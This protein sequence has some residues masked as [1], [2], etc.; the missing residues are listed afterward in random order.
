MTHEVL[1]LV[2]FL[3]S[4]SNEIAGNEQLN[5]ELFGEV[6]IVSFVT[7]PTLSL[8]KFRL[9]NYSSS[10]LMASVESV[11]LELGEEHK[12]LTDITLF[13]LE[14]DEE[15]DPAGFKIGVEST[16]TFLV[17]FPRL[18]YKPNYGDSTTIGLK[19]RVDGMEL[20]AQSPIIF[21]RRYPYDIQSRGN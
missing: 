4:Q 3:M 8:G 10:P 11:W 6:V 5:A 19:L 15:M 13:S 2:L 16:E 1:A 9:E 18:A 14:R 20:V 12:K 21:E 17:G 7:D